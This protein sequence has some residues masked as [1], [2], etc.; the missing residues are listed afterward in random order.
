[1]LAPMNGYDRHSDDYN[2]GD[3]PGPWTVAAIA[4]VLI[5]I[6]VGPAVFNLWAG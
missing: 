4:A 3:F 6:A 2:G 1:M 5:L